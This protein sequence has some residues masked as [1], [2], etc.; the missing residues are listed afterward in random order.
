MS[1]IQLTD[2]LTQAYL[3]ERLE[4]NPETGLWKWRL[5]YTGNGKKQEWFLGAVSSRSRYA[6]IKV[7]YIQYQA[8]RLA[9]LYIYG[10]WPDGEIDHIN[11]DRKDNR[12]A[13]LRDV[14]HPTNMRARRLA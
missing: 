5:G 7:S 10:K 1:F 2:H 4:Y 3:K 8:H 11:G 9:W 12:I 14:D 13:N 6:S